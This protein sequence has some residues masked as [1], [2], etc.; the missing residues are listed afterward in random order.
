[1]SAQDVPDT[2]VALGFWY[3][4]RENHFYSEELCEAYGDGFLARTPDA[5]WYQCYRNT[6]EVKWTISIYIQ[7]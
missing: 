2:F 5:V 3:T 6:G 7:T 1:M 4:P